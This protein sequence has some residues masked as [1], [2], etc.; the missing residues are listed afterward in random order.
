MLHKEARTLNLS[1]GH[2]FA[3]YFQILCMPSLEENGWIENTESLTQSWQVFKN[4]YNI[5]YFI[6]YCGVG[7][8]IQF[9]FIF[10]GIYYFQIN[11]WLD[12]F[13]EKSFKNWNVLF[14]SFDWIA[15]QS[16]LQMNNGLSRIFVTLLSHREVKQS[17]LLIP[18]LFCAPFLFFHILSCV[19]ICNLCLDWWV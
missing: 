11:F 12:Q 9:W 6:F 10:I 4:N 1:P 18:Y 8:E 15:L 17:C 5:F 19:Y 2:P 7:R 14:K 13:N 16:F 3:Y